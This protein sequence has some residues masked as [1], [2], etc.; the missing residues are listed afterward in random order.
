MSYVS[1]VSFL[2]AQPASKATC[3]A[4]SYKVNGPDGKQQNLNEGEGSETI[5]M[6]YSKSDTSGYADITFRENDCGFGYTKGT[7]D[8]N[9]SAGSKTQTVYPCLKPM[10]NPNARY[11]VLDVQFATSDWKGKPVCPAGYTMDP[12]NLNTNQG[13]RIHLCKRF[14]L[15]TVPLNVPGASTPGT[16]A[17]DTISDWF[18][19]DK[20]WWLVGGGVA[21]CACV[22]CCLVL[23][24]V[25]ASSKKG[26]GGSPYPY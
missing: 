14:G 3:P 5:Y 20:V 11:G 22:C 18:S 26:G 17:A 13:K 2:Y 8:V 23:V 19:G 1:D 12:Q 10:T 6:C 16:G 24:M 15:G 4:G 25:M 21:L 9:Q 7:Q